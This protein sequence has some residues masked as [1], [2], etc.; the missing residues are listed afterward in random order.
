MPSGAASATSSIER[1][2]IVDNVNGTPAAAA[3]RAVASSASGCARPWIAIG[4]MATGIDAGDPSSV[5]DGIDPGDV[6]QHPRP[7]QA[8]R[9]GGLVV[10]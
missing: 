10:G 2:A 4:A 5:V 9:P 8:A 1:D 6:H 7:E 3:A